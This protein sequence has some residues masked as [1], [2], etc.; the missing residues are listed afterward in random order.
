[1]RK[2]TETYKKA[3]IRE[4]LLR[5]VKGHSDIQKGSEIREREFRYVKGHSH[6]Q[7][8][9]WKVIEICETALIYVKGTEIYKKTLRYAKGHRDT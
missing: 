6:V 8:A 3:D 7:N 4:R 5:Y 2:D 9:L 1:M